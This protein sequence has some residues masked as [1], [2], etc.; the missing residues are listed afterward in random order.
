M[1]SSLTNQAATTRAT[2]MGIVMPMV[3]AGLIVSGCSSGEGSPSGGSAGFDVRALSP[4]ADMVSG[5][6][7]LVAVALPEGVVS[8]D[9]SVSIGGRDVSQAFRVAPD[10]A[11]LVGL[12][13]GLPEGASTIQANAGGQRAALD[14]VNYPLQG[15][16]FSG[17]H[18]EPFVC[19][20]E[21]Y[22]LPGTPD[23]DCVVPT[24]VSYRY[25]TRDG[26]FQPYD[27]DA[28]APED[29]TQTTTSDG[30]TVDFIVRQEAGVI[31]RAI[32]E[33]AFLHQPGEPLPDTWT[34]TPGWNGRLIFTFGG[35]CAPAYKQGRS[36]G[37]TSRGFA[38]DVA[39][40]EGYAVASSSLNVFGNNCND[41][42]SA[43]AMLMVKEHFIET[44]GV[45]EYTVGYG[46]SGGAM[47][48]HLIANNYPGLLDGILPRRSY[49]DTFS[50]APAGMDCV[51]LERATRGGNVA[52]TDKARSAVAG[53]AG[54]SNC[55]IPVEPGEQ[56]EFYTWINSGFAHGWMTPEPHPP[57]IRPDCNLQVLGDLVYDTGTNPDGADC[58]IYGN[59]VN[60]IGVNPETGM[61]YR[62]YDNLGVQY[63]LAA[64]NNGEI[65]AE[66]FV[67]LNERVGG[68]D[69]S[70]HLSPERADAPLEAVKNAHAFG[71]INNAGG[72]L[73]E[74]PII[75]FRTYL[76]QLPDIHDRVRSFAMRAR[77]EAANGHADNQVM[78]V[79][80]QNHPGGGSDVD[81]T[82]LT[83][84][85][86]WLTAI[87]ADREPGSK[88]ERVVRNK[89]A[90]L[91]DGCYSEA[92]DWIAEPASRT[93]GQC[94]TMYPP[95]GDP[96]VAAT[97]PV[98]EDIL[99]CQLKPLATNGY[100][101]LLTDSQF[102]RLQDVFPDGVCDY[103]Q[104][105]SMQPEGMADWHAWR[106]YS[107]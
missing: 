21:A 32:Y 63:G 56:P 62:L 40:A 89:P 31:N 3:L 78:I 53:F 38:G 48:Q 66:Q 93:D 8:A 104:P 95:H 11:S 4:R 52:W 107:G 24:Q 85:G 72:G 58:S 39:L 65:S 20:T 44:Y 59:A 23:D 43:E 14:V 33:V 61:A 73:A 64:F 79:H 35:G 92:G 41:V 67:E 105:G 55:I 99:K 45:P 9:V 60:V 49:P 75:D 5:G 50:L 10:G 70:G 101:Q 22:G 15:P 87:A 36:T 29:L 83:W 84:M 82:M 68:F 100:A 1:R 102:A 103:T 2:S 54:W 28:P 90:G 98:S 12:V 81:A 96:R 86:Q 97:Q 19:E 69:A 51:L 46:G 88:A 57:E 42:T 6:D 13:T 25:R 47:Q 76:E 71:R 16:I 80:H 18:Q 106:T 17:P 94:A 34:D 37:G 91:S 7:V 77:L 26:N 30:A 74:I 27:P